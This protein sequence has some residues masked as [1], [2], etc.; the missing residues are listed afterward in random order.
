MLI[1]LSNYFVLKKTIN[2]LKPSLIFPC[3]ND[4]LASLVAKCTA[5]C[6]PISTLFL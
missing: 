3:I 1:L 5:H 4:F 6:D 2:K